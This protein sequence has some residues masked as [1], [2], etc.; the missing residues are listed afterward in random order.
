MK[1]LF[2]IALVSL[3]VSSC[4]N[5]AYQAEFEKNTKIAKAYFK[6]HEEENAD[7]MFE[8]LHPDMEWHFRL[9]HQVSSWC[10]VLGSSSR[11]NVDTCD[12]R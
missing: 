6:L 2:V 11:P 7:A 10:E 8:Y 4:S 5:N 9:R 3:I 1:K 12:A